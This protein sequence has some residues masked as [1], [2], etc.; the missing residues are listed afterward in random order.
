MKINCSYE[1]NWFRFLGVF[2]WGESLRL[3]KALGLKGRVGVNS[4]WSWSGG[5]RA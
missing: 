3:G 5:L 2:G 4:T 1:C